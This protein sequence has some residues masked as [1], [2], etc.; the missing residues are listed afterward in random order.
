MVWVLVGRGVLSWRR[1]LLLRIKERDKRLSFALQ[2]FSAKHLALQLGLL[3]WAHTHLK[4][5]T[6]SIC[7]SLLV[8]VPSWTPNTHV[9]A[10]EIWECHLCGGCVSARSP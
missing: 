2:I 9:A 3:E 5:C 8:G 1:M 10:R 6:S 4:P 7:F